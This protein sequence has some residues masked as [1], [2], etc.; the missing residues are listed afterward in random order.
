MKILLTHSPS[1]LANYYGLRALATLQ[2]AGTVRLRSFEGPWALEALIE[3]AQDCQL[4]VSHRSTAAPAELL[5]RLPNLVAFSRCAVDIRNVDVQAASQLGILVTQASPG[6]VT[7]VT[8]WIVGAMIDVSRNITNAAMDYRAGRTPAAAMGRE[9][10][11]ATLGIIGLGRIGQNLVDVALALGMRVVG[12]DPYLAAA[13]PG[14]QM[15]GF[16]ALFGQA[17]YVVCLAV[18]TEATENMI[19]AKALARM[20]PDAVFINPGR[21]NLVDEAALLA[22]LEAGH[23]G[24]CALDVGRAPDQ[25][26]SP[27]LARH[28]RVLATPHIGGL[29]LPAMEHQSMETAQQAADLAAGKVPVG[30]VNASEAFRAARFLAQRG[31][32]GA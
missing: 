4:I 25:M 20:K 6:F 24:G 12:H 23:L 28:P 2:A 31:Q 27:A 1:D 30:A 14:V 10:R 32:V 5:A 29:T 17:D 15:L 7:S 9:L 11:G 18:A 26:P 19:D 8:E 3:A 22:A 16:E 21:G 13:K